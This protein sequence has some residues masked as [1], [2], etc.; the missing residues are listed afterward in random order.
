MLII[1]IGVDA[2]LGMA[3]GVKESL[4]MFLEQFGD[5]RV[6]EIKETRP[7]QESLFQKRGGAHESR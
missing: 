6:L 1:T 2:P 5:A 7:R 4:A 3:Q